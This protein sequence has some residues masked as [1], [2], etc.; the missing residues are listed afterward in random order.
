MYFLSIF[1]FKDSVAFCSMQIATTTYNFE[2]LVLNNR[3]VIGNCTKCKIA[4]NKDIVKY[5]GCL[6]NDCMRERSK[7]VS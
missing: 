5:N 3:E 2:W 6:F 4:R 1:L 7:T